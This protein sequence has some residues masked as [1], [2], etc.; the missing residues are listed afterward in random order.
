M[1][2]AMQQSSHTPL[3]IQ[4]SLITDRSGPSR[5]RSI[6]EWN[7]PGNQNISSALSVEGQANLLMAQSGVSPT[8][9]ICQ[10]EYAIPEIDP[11]CPISGGDGE[12]DDFDGLMGDGQGHDDY[13][14][15]VEQS[16]AHQQPL[17]PS[18]MDAY[19]AHVEFLKQMGP[20]SIP[21][22]YDSHNNFWLPQKSNFFFLHGIANPGWISCIIP[23]FFIG[24]QT[25]WL[26]GDCIAQIVIPS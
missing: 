19:H 13:N 24:T 4:P 25:I 9:D 8:V 18:V 3:D 7:I 23:G 2:K 26:K 21:K 16:R 15:E 1:L 17:P 20:H 10:T 5:Q 11:N 6:F 22:L 14:E 12:G